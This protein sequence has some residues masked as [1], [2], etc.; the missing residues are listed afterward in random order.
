M[1]ESLRSARLYK[2]S[3]ISGLMK[4]SDSTIPM[5]LPRAFL[6]PRFIVSPYPVFS[7]ST[8]TMRLSDSAYFCIIDRDESVEPSFR[9]I[10]SILR[11]V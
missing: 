3:N 2:S 9:Q 6:M 5:Y 7:L 8:T 1:S 10:I 11:S 4:S